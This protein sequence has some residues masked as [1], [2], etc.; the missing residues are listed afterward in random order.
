MRHALSR[1]YWSAQVS[2]V[3]L[4]G[5]RF[6]GNHWLKV[7]ESIKYKLLS[8]RYKVL[9]TAQPSNLHNLISLQPPRSTR[10]SSVVV[11]LSCPPTV[12]QPSPW[13]SQIAHL[14]MHHLVFGINFQNHSVSLN[15]LVSIH[16]LIHFSI[17]L[18]RF[19]KWSIKLQLNFALYGFGDFWHFSYGISSH[20][21]VQFCFP[22]LI[23]SSSSS[24]FVQIKIHDAR[25]VHDK[26]WTG[27]Q[28]GKN[29]TYC[30]PWIEKEKK[31]HRICIIHYN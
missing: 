20:Y 18:C 26:T 15:I 4:W 6:S 25:R 21:F 27:Q 3:F 17:H 29:H 1:V 10:S 2:A 9:T 16:I 5:R 8:L 31:K 13:K 11:T 7:N 22:C 30:C 19:M 12:P 24:L 14:D 28:G 23:S